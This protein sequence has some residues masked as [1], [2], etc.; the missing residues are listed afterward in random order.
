MIMGNFWL[1]PGCCIWRLYHL[2]GGRAAFSW[3]LLLGGFFL[4]GGFFFSWRLYHLDEGR[5]GCFQLEVG[6]GCS[7]PAMSCLPTEE[8]RSHEL[9]APARA[10]QAPPPNLLSQPS[11]PSHTHTRTNTQ[12]P[13]LSDPLPQ[14]L[15]LKMAPCQYLMGSY[16]LWHFSQPDQ[17][18]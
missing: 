16:Q 7:A 14:N 11:P 5:E 6:G 4:A 3:R 12:P 15:V 18:R 2:E 9:K 8:T 10:K 17:R 13:Q 1:L